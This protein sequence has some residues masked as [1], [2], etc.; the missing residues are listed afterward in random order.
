MWIESA[1]N[2]QDIT[3]IYS[4]S[5]HAVSA[6]SDIKGILRVL[7][8]MFSQIKHLAIVYRVGRTRAYRGIK[9]VHFN[10]F[11]S[12]EDGFL[13]CSASASASCKGLR[14]A[15]VLIAR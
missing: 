3:I 10:R 11:F 1:V 15:S 12:C 7:D 9:S 8:Q 6:H 4:G 2:Y 13:P 14:R 5:I